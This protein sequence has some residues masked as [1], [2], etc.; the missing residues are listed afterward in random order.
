ME[1]NRMVAT[2]FRRPPRIALF[3]RNY[4]YTLDG[5]NKSLNRLVGHLQS[6]LDTGA[7]TYSPT[8]RT[9][10]FEP[11]GDLISVPSVRIPFRSDYRV[12]FGLTASTRRDI[13]AFGPD[14]IHL[15]V[16]DA[17]G[18][19]ALKLGRQLYVPVVASLHTLFVSPRRPTT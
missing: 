8:S 18:W 13:E 3:S 14:L 17:L 4:N 5:A 12:S 10:A 11:V 9:P 16:P 15:S 7:S 19:S 1:M 6:T 2:R